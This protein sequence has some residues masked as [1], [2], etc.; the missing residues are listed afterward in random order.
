MRVV[1]F[2]LLV[3]TGL[4]LSRGNSQNRS[5][6]PRECPVWTKFTLSNGSTPSSGSCL[7][8][9]NL[10]GIVHCHN[11][12]GAETMTNC[13]CMTSQES[14]SSQTEEGGCGE[15]EEEEDER[16]GLG[17]NG[18]CSSTEG[19]NK[20]NQDPLLVGP[21]LYTC[22][23]WRHINYQLQTNMSQDIDQEICGPYNRT[24]RLCGRCLSETGL[25]A[26]SYSLLCVNC[27]R[28]DYHLNWLRYIAVAYGPLTIFFFAVVSLRI[29]A[30]SGWL[31]GFVIISQMITIRAIATLLQNNARSFIRKRHV[32]VVYAVPFMSVWNLD[33]GCTWHQPFCLHPDLSILH[34]LLLDYGVALYPMLL[35]ALTFFLVRAHGRFRVISWLWRPLYACLHHFKKEWD[36]SS[37]LIGAFATFYLLSY[38]KVLNVT[39]DILA[40]VRLYNI[41]GG[42][43]YYYYYN[44]SMPYFGSQ[45]R[46]YAVVA[47]V[48]GLLYNVLPFFLFCLYPCGCFQRCL[49]RASCRCRLLHTFM[50]AVLGDFSHKPRE[51]RYF[52][53]YHL[54]LRMG[55]VVAATLLNTYTYFCFAS[56]IMVTT[57][58]LVALLK[59]YENVWHNRVEMILFSCLAHVYLMFVFYQKSLSADPLRVTNVRTVYHYSMNIVVA[60]IPVY[61]VL[62][63]LGRLLPRR[64]LYQKVVFLW[65][66]LSR[67]LQSGEREI[68]TLPYRM[69]EEEKEHLLAPPL[70]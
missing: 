46:P 18:G 60:V 23:L 15:E 54:L 32:F 34:M 5:D 38:V 51:R 22:T 13:F 56:Y 25:P 27:S 53:A 39:A 59:P 43:R 7:C 12:T 33:F 24:G 3:M 62:L 35:I 41:S 55:H 11:N 16:R 31:A 9:S 28:S 26:Y 67:K 37:S 57:V 6:G 36:V 2:L 68:T 29:S 50:D 30:T 20:R 8:G 44:A 19:L 64:R 47:I 4:F 58:V 70:I 21:C 42:F 69:Q 48:A 40:P 63:L 1:V 10:G 45:H 61:G 49:N 52:G 66:R 14:P 17:T 65:E